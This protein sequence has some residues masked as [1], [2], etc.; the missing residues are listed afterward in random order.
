MHALRDLHFPAAALGTFV[1]A[2]TAAAPLSNVAWQ[3]L[4]ERKGSRRLL[5]YASFIAALAPL[6]ALLAGKLGWP[7]LAYSLVFVCS[8]VALQG[9]NLGNT[10]H[11]L[12]ISQPESRSRTIG[13]LN[14]LVGVAL[15]APVLGALPLTTGGTNPF[16]F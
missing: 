9:F 3:R 6:T 4:A 12:N 13:T 14:T 15:F 7:P 1:M 5:R 8:S 11:L 16:S 10:N 2:T